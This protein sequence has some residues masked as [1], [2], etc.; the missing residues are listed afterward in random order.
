MALCED[1]AALA[2]ALSGAR[3]DETLLALCQ[4]AE[5]L[6]RARLR[7]DAGESCGELLPLATALLALSFRGAEGAAERIRVGDFS[8]ENASGMQAGRALREQAYALLQPWL[9]EQN[10]G[11]QGVLMA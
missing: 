10:F 2:A 8:V 11:F 3:D 1:A 7:E 6:V 5:A 9:K 4:A